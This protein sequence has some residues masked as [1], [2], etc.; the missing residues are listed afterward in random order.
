MNF[1]KKGK[2]NDVLSIIFLEIVLSYIVYKLL[3]IYLLFETFSTDIMLQENNSVTLAIFIVPLI[4][5]V[6]F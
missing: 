4:S 1:Q 2:V 3:G 6:P 5:N